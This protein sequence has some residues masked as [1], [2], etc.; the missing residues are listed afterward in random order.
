[1]IMMKKN[2]PE[3]DASIAARYYGLGCSIPSLL[4]LIL[5]GLIVAA[6]ISLSISAFT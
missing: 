1:M 2:R 5:V 6:T 3:S 4:F